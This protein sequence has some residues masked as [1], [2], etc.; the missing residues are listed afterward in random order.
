MSETY[1]GVPTD[2]PRIVE[3]IKNMVR[4]GQSREDICRIVGMPHEV[5]EKY[6]REVKREKSH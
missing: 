3:Y 5:V 2:H 4:Q 1:Q 6:E